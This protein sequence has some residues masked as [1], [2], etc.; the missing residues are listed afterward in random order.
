LRPYSPVPLTSYIPRHY[1]TNTHTLSR[2]LS[3]SLPPTRTHAQ[4]LLRDLLDSDVSFEREAAVLR[5]ARDCASLLSYVG[6]SCNFGVPCISLAFLGSLWCSLG[7][8]GL[9]SLWRSVR[10][11]LSLRDLRGDEWFL[12]NFLV[13]SELSLVS[14]L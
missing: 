1:I 9:G 3:L 11:F 6:L 12:P 13:S 7:L 8:F 4:V 5:Y 14:C 10:H 2:A